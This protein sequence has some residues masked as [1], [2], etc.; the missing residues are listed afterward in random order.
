M[1]HDLSMRPPT[2]IIRGCPVCGGSIHRAWG[3]RDGDCLGCG[4]TFDLVRARMAPTAGPSIGERLAA[5]QVA[6]VF[7]AMTASAS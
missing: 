7:K 6:A 4:R 3:A 5:E 2:W 1:A